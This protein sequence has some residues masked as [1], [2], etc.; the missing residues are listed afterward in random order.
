MAGVRK[1]GKKNNRYT[2]FFKAANGEVKELERFPD[3]TAADKLAVFAM[4]HRK[5]IARVKIQYQRDEFTAA[6]VVGWF[7]RKDG[8]IM[9]HSVKTGEDHAIT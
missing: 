8:A 9:Y 6:E 1:Q 3:Q 4:V 7:F 5:D 2:A